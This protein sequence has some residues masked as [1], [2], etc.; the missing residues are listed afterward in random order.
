MSR[1]KGKKT[2]RP[3]DI[4]VI[5]SLAES[6]NK[7]IHIIDG[8]FELKDILN[9]RFFTSQSTSLPQYIQRL[10]E[11]GLVE[12]KRGIFEDKKGRKVKKYL[13]RLIPTPKV[14]AYIYQELSLEESQ[15]ILINKNTE[16]IRIIIDKF[17]NSI[18]SKKIKEKGYNY[19]EK[20]DKDLI[21]KQ[22][23]LN[24]QQLLHTANI[25]YDHRNNE[26]FSPY[27]ERTQN[28]LNFIKKDIE[29]AFNDYN[30]NIKMQYIEYSK[31]IKKMLEEK[32][33]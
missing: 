13:W 4:A 20:K 14:W 30:K 32:K 16:K 1:K 28:E 22:Y 27:K 8:W 5:L 3:L 31:K 19:M 2:L 7:K 6:N 15:G 25:Y 26:E 24:I 29:K 17:E 23:F 12:R 10:E 33:T 9:E 11:L 18:Y 21:E